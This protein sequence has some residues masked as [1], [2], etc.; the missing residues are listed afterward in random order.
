MLFSY[1]VRLVTECTLGQIKEKPLIVAKRIAFFE[2]LDNREEEVTKKTKAA[3][4]VLKTT[5]NRYQAQDLVLDAAWDVLEEI[6]NGKENPRQQKRRIEQRD[7]AQRKA[8]KRVRHTRTQFI[9]ALEAYRKTVPFHWRWL[10]EGSLPNN[11][12]QE[13][14]EVHWKDT[15][16]K[17]A[18]P[19]ILED[20]ITQVGAIIER[21]E[22][23]VADIRPFQ[24]ESGQKRG[25]QERKGLNNAIVELESLFISCECSH[26]K[27]LIHT[28]S[29]L[30]FAGV[31]P[32]FSPRGLTAKA[33]NLKPHSPSKNNP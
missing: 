22:Q 26:R 11:V 19:G 6:K 32:D 2:E 31:W 7:T 10:V 9:A 16:A 3:W 1:R 15:E 14:K 25:R 12:T 33:S 8:Y 29:L 28:H 21:L 13:E 20:S 18:L 30:L 5:L 23:A 27:A 17:W 24:K 4:E